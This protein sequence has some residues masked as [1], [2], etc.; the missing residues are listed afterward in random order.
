[1]SV[2]NETDEG[3]QEGLPFLV[4]EQEATWHDV[5]V[6]KDLP[7]VDRTKILTMLECFSDILMDVSGEMNET[8]HVITLSYKTPIRVRQYS[9][10]L[11]YEESIK[12]ELM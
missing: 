1:M 2:I 11:H 8:T 12:M 5:A 3:F 6:D 4:F 10:P 7:E 9:L